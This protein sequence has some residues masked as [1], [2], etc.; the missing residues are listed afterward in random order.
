[1]ISMNKLFWGGLG[2]AVFGP[3]GGIL[4]DVMASDDI[5]TARSRPSSGIFSGGP[6]TTT[7]A[8]D[9]GLSM[10]VLFAAVM[11]AD[12]QVLKSELEFVK[13]FFIKQF[14]STYAKERIALFQDILKQEYPLRDVCRQIKSNMDHP[15]RLQ[16]IHVLFGL[17][18]ADGHVHP[19]EVNIIRDITGYLGISQKDFESIKAMFYKDTQSSYTILEIDK[20]ATDIEVKKAFRRM[21]TKYHPDKV[22]HL[23]EEFRSIAEEKFKK[24]NEAYQQVKKERGI[25]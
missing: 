3:I 25:S 9:F 20:S 13:Q 15:A 8:G 5:K 16:M 10:L 24:V 12:G 22:S 23:G 21:A 2:W 18:Q 17:S 19:S 1:M 11:K 7:R 6:K 4:G 14:G